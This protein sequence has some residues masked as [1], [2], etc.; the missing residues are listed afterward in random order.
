MVQA[1]LNT[2]LD[3]H[4]FATFLADERFDNADA[5]EHVG[6]SANAAGV[7][8]FGSGRIVAPVEARGR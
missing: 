3:V 1:S 2:P 4:P 6:R 7:N 5:E 8:L